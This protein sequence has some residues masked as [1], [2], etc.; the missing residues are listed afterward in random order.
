M[1]IVR[2]LSG[3]AGLRDLK[4][5]SAGTCVSWVN[6]QAIASE[7]KLCTQLTRLCCNCGGWLMDELEFPGAPDI[8]G[9]GFV[10]VLP[11]LLSLEHL[12]LS[13]ADLAEAQALELSCLTKLSV[14]EL[15]R[16]RGV[17]GMVATAV[18]CR[19]PHLAE[20]D[21]SNCQ[22]AS[23]AVLPVLGSLSRLQKLDLCGN[24]V[25]I[26]RVGLSM[27]SGLTALTELSIPYN[28]EVCRCDEHN[29]L[30]G[31]PGLKEV[32]GVMDECYS[33]PWSPGSDFGY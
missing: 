15:R 27:L 18:A 24:P 9:P 1:D 19:L 30:A 31:M 4:L 26:D 28:S 22:L 16:C 21:V 17:T 11:G 2:Q 5:L 12:S 3:L 33:E 29:F 8:M 14:L 20:L 13:D 7:L 10:G 6:V 25:R 32:H 23:R